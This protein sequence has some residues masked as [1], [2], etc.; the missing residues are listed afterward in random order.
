MGVSRG[1]KTV[2]SVFWAFGELVGGTDGHAQQ[3]VTLTTN[4]LSLLCRLLECAHL[5]I[6]IYIHLGQNKQFLLPVSFNS[7]ERADT[8]LLA[9]ILLLSQ[10]VSKSLPS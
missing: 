7:Q 8:A 3:A 2:A 4:L 5:K 10:M 6:H 1:V 9:L